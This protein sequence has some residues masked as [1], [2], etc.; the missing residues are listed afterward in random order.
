MLLNAN[1]TKKKK[2]S[3]RLVSFTRKQLEKEKVIKKILEF[4]VTH[5]I[6]EKNIRTFF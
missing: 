4:F 5:F 2:T 1:P 6:Y 3:L